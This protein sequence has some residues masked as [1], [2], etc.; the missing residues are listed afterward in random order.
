MSRRRTI[1]TI[2]QRRSFF[3]DR[4]ETSECDRSIAPLPA[5]LMLVRPLGDLA[6]VVC[7]D[8][9]CVTLTYNGRTKYLLMMSEAV[10]DCPLRDAVVA[11]KH[12]TPSL[13]RR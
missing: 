2:A 13:A 1:A 8:R 12:R 10:L 7:G 6:A 3:R 5:I 11:R 9:V 4:T